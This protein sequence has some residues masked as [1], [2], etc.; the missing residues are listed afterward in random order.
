MFARAALVTSASK[1]VAEVLKA[2]GKMMLTILVTTSRTAAFGVLLR[3]EADGNAESSNISRTPLR[4]R[5]AIF[6]IRLSITNVL[7]SLFA[8]V[9]SQLRPKRPSTILLRVVQPLSLVLSER[10]LRSPP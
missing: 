1:V 2:P 9:G 10:P 8:D 7:T 6:L 3:S 4:S 5:L